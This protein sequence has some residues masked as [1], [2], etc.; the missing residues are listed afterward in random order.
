VEFQALAADAFDNARRRPDTDE[1]DLD[2]FF[3]K[4][5]LSAASEFV[6]RLEENR[7][8]PTEI[9]QFAQNFVFCQ[10]V[11]YGRQGTDPNLEAVDYALGTPDTY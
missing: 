6:S 2:V 7:K 5:V 10:L 11:K 9:R 4:T 3:V 1:D 8:P